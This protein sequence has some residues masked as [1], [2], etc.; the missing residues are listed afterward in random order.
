MLVVDDKVDAALG[1]LRLHR[2]EAFLV[3]VELSLL[4]HDMA[5]GQNGDDLRRSS[6]IHFA[7]FRV[8]KSLIFCLSPLLGA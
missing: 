5:E 3:D 2:G 6:D 4:A 7:P 8:R 1:D